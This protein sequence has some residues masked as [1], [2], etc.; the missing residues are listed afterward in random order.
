M[1][2]SV[3]YS[4]QRSEDVTLQVSM[5][6]PTNIAGWNIQFLSQLHFGGLSGLITKSCASGYGGGQSGITVIN[7][8]QG[9]FNISIA[10]QDT[11]GFQFA[12][13]SYCTTRLDSGSVSVLNE[14]FVNILPSMGQ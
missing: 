2:I 12:P 11:S 7:S 3:N 10:S 8:G 4:L 9:Q 13:Y 5:V 1:T 14:G 6:P